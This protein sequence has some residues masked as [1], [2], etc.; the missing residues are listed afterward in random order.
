MYTMKTFSKPNEQLQCIF[1]IGEFYGHVYCPSVGTD[2][3]LGT[4]FYQ[5]HK[6]SV[7]LP[8]SSHF[9][10][11]NDILKDSPIQMHGLPMF[12]LNYV[13]VITVSQFLYTLQYSGHKC[14]MPISFVMGRPVR[15]KIYERPLPYLGM[16]AILVIIYVHIGSSFL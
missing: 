12:T 7:H 11:S 9:F 4:I 1:P 8:I 5:N 14:H 16:A 2:Q 13:I 15:G 6:S 3:P 10:P